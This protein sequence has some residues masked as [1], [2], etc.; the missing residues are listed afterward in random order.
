MVDYANARSTTP[1]SSLGRLVVRVDLCGLRVGLA[2]PLLQ[3]PE[4]DAGGGHAGA[5]GV[6]QL[7]ERDRADLG[8]LERLAE[9]A[10]ELGAVERMAGLGVAEDEILV[11]RVEGAVAQLGECVGDALGHRD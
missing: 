11:A 8:V 3:R 7:V 1:A 9:A 10:D 2:H 4:R 5:E 6:A